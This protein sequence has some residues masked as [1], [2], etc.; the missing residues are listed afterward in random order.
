MQGGV[1]DQRHLSRAEVARLQRAYRVDGDVAARERL[2]EAYL[3]LARALARGFAH[4]GEQ[5]DDLVQVGSIGLI[6]A[7]DRF[8]PAR[9][10]DLA[11]FAAPTIVGE[12]K[13]H[14]RDRSG[15]IRVPRRQQEA[16]AQVG[17]TRRQLTG[18]LQRSPTQVELVA[19]AGLTDAELADASRAEH[20]RA[21]VALAEDSGVTSRDVFEATDDRVAVS[22][23]MRSLHRRERQVLRCRYFADMSQR[24][25]AGRL[26]ISQTHASRLLASGLAKLRENLDRNAEFAARSELHSPHG[27]ARRRPGRAA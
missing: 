3:P 16:N 8:E 18:R 11:A 13:R 12:I 27:D 22:T 19:A 17:R 2:I 25:I 6:N 23:G 26:G 1:K 4:R 20:A 24:E 10:V 21:P 14:L 5:V 7:V 9:G 15:L